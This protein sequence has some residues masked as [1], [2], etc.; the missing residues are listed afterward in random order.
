MRR[1]FQMPEKSND[2]GWVWT[3]ELGVP[4]ASMLTT[5]PPKSSI[6][7]LNSFSDKL[8]PTWWC[9]QQRWPKH[10]L[11]KLYTLDNIV[12]L[13]LL[14]PYRIITSRTQLP[15][16]TNI[17]TPSGTRTSRSHQSSCCISTSQQ[18]TIIPLDS[19]P[20]PLSVYTVVLWE[21]IM[22]SSSRRFFD[23]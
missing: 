16:E 1:I 8:Y 2:F 20:S 13:W 23:N 10:V 3:R 17:H 18:S 9:P 15:Q 21:A 11:D 19:T 14:Y 4:E 7:C 22:A 6:A 12:V 5:R